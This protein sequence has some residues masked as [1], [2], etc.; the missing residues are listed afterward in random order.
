MKKAEKDKQKLILI[1]GPTAVGKTDISIKIAEKF[2]GEIIS[3]DSM[4]IYKGMDIGTA[5]IKDEEMRGIPHHMIDIV[6]P[7]EDFS[8]SDFKEKAYKYI[9]EIAER[10]NIPIAAG[11]T[12]FYV[13]SLVYN[14]NFADSGSDEE[15]REK[16]S[17]LAEE[18]GNEY[19]ME[20]LRK[21]DPESADRIN[22]NDRKRIV[23]AIEVYEVS[24]RKMS[25]TYKDFRKENEDFHL[26]MI[27]LN[28]DRQKLY[29]RINRRVDIMLEEGLVDEV[30][31]LLER[32]YDKNLTSMKAIGY[33]EVAEYI[34]DSIS[35]DEMTE[36]LKRNSRRFAKRQLTW[37]RRDKRIKWFN[38][39]DYSSENEAF[40]EIIDYIEK[41]I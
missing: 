18:K 14:L 33:K 26:I 25:E 1:V 10:G 36:I 13:N 5:K 31:S 41:N 23:R 22:I 32:G 3:A 4:Q 11:G 9:E 29:D 37:F 2:G 38:Y 27:G 28:R 21:I 15:V 20:I 7:D 34:E 40:E 12:G 35:Y 17:S 6:E 19:I 30:R 39:D 24:G 8:V 16:Y